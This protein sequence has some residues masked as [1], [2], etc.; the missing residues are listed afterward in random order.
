MYT[1]FSFSFKSDWLII[2]IITLTTSHQNEFK[3]DLDYAIYRSV[4]SEQLLDVVYWFKYVVWAEEWCLTWLNQV[5]LCVRVMTCKQN[6][7]SFY[8]RFTKN[9]RTGTQSCSLS[10][11]H[12]LTQSSQAWNEYSAIY[13]GQTQS[14]CTPPW[15]SREKAETEWEEERGHEGK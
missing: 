7:K 15:S 5:D 12:T 8:N 2:A 6:M 3:S 11:M 10:R 9:V 1:F 4:I 14:P 13:L